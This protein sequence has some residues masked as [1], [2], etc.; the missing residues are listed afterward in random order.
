MVNLCF[1]YLRWCYAEVN[2]FFYK[3]IMN[4]DNRI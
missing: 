2:T 4:F 1:V 3:G